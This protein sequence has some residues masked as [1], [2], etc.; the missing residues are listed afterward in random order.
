MVSNSF[1]TAGNTL[2]LDGSGD[3]IIICHNRKV[4]KPTDEQDEGMK[5]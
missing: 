3:E 4:E 5:D 2:E 1:K